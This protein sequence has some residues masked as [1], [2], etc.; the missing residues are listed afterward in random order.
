MR[1]LQALLVVLFFAITNSAASQEVRS[2]PE[3]LSATLNDYILPGYARL[4]S[5][6][7]TL[8]DATRILCKAP[9]RNSLETAQAAFSKAT[10]AWAQV[11]WFRIGPVTAH[12]NVERMLFY[13]DR[14]STGL[15]QVQA[16]LV[17]RHQSTTSRQSLSQKSVAMQGLGALEY[18][19]FGKGHRHLIMPADE[20]RCAYAMAIGA[21][22]DSISGVLLKSWQEDVSTRVAWLEPSQTNP[23]FRNREEAVARLV[24]T[25][26]HGLEAVKDVRI[27][28]FLR[29]NPDRDRPKS[30]V[31]WR[32]GNTLPTIAEGLV[33]LRNLFEL[34][35]VETV[36][37]AEFAD[38][39]NTVKLEFDFA[40]EAAR[41]LD[42]PVDQLLA[43]PAARKRL[44]YLKLA[45]KQIIIR[46][47]GE[48]LPAIG[49]HSGFSF[50]DGD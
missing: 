11:E 5:A 8:A 4:K 2:H 6:T 44:F 47:D 36:L 16:A 39:G 33:G 21:N 50:G 1:S 3:I 45:I 10:A 32:S 17:S 25:L 18:L 29:K 35:G 40:I 22:L 30:A 20:Y 14:K 41:S 43:D 31:L 46:L 27:G 15:R 42:R 9:S 23:W 7:A 28:A 38:L 13:P 19:L 48:F 12:N 34:S 26:V 49:L 37:P 24:G